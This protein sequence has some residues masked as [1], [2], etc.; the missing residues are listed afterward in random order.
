VKILGIVGSPR[1]RANSTALL[2]QLLSGAQAEGAQTQTIRPWEKRIGPCLACDGCYRDGRCVVRDG[3]QSVYDLI[4]D[5]DALALATPVYFGAVS[6]Q[7]KP[8]IDRCQCFWAMREVIKATMP[9]GP[10]GVQRRGV[11]IATAGQACEGM[12]DGV[13]A[14]FRYLMRSLQ[15]QMYAELLYGGYDER[16]AILANREAMARA[17]NVGRRLALGLESEQ[18]PP[19]RKRSTDWR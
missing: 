1:R 15:G 6:A 11:L 4:L 3:F 9:P 10:A 18:A 2:E 14:T 12:F 17:Y 16:G 13:R 7:A 8:L 5:S 19:Y